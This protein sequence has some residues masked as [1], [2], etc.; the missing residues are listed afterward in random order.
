METFAFV[1]KLN[2]LGTF[3]VSAKCAAQMA[4]QEAGEDGEKGCIIN[5]AY[6]R[7]SCV[8]HARPINFIEDSQYSSRSVLRAGFDMT[9]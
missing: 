9:R 2:L 3:S 6:A 1:V 4:K 7:D 5:V 8:V